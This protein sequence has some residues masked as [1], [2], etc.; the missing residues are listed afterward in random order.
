MAAKSQQMAANGSKW[1]QMDFQKAL[2]SIIQMADAGNASVYEGC[3]YIF[4]YVYICLCVH[5]NRNTS[6]VFLF[7][8][9]QNNIEA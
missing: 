2:A 6:V 1:Q 7:L 4:I 5:I 9:P 3:M 8:K